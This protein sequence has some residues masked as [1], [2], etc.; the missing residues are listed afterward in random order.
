MALSASVSRAITDAVK[1]L[2]RYSNG[3]YL[4]D[5]VRRLPWIVDRSIPVA[6]TDGDTFYVNP[7]GWM[8]YTA[9]Y[10]AYIVAHEV[11]HV[12]CGHGSRGAMHSRKD[13]DFSQKMWNIA[14]DAVVNLLV[15]EW[16][17]TLPAPP[18]RI[19]FFSLARRGA[20]P[21]RFQFVRTSCLPS[22]EEVYSYLRK[23][24][25]DNDDKLPDDPDSN[26]DFSE[27]DTS[28]DA[29]EDAEGEAG[30]D[31]GEDGDDNADGGNAGGLSDGDEIEKIEAEPDAED[32]GGDA[33]GDQMS[34]GMA[35]SVELERRYLHN[36]CQIG[37]AVLRNYVG[38]RL[39]SE[40]S[41]RRLN[42][43]FSAVGVPVPSRSGRSKPK[44]VSIAFDRSVSQRPE[45]LKLVAQ[46]LETLKRQ[47]RG[48]EFEVFAWSIGVFRIDGVVTDLT[49]SSDW[50]SGQFATARVSGACSGESHGKH[51]KVRYPA[52]R[53]WRKL[54]MN[55][56][57]TLRAISDG[58]CKIGG[59]T[60][61]SYA[62]GFHADVCKADL[63]VVVTDGQFAEY[64]SPDGEGARHLKLDFPS[65]RFVFAITGKDGQ[66]ITPAMVLRRAGHDVV[67]LD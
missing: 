56:R 46:T 45:S 47:F 43:R 55:C 26:D 31:G 67:M 24:N 6:A 15:D 33:A 63:C 19:T 38:E 60:D 54:V 62:A 22:A 18:D 32:A 8:A 13:P 10:R 48:L 9:D 12:L 16:L 2:S 52:G 30:E 39:R 27:S 37:P 50:S 17:D 21:H 11:A 61:F 36:G 23:H 66:N 53:P 44:R 41:F 14:V 25:E 5:I 49:T 35:H 42:T 34:D 51:L 57:D 29:G 1:T 64:T 4:A 28:G 3:R 20:L 58:K 40:R 7:E 59:G 65:K